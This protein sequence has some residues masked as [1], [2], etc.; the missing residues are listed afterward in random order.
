MSRKHARSIDNNYYTF[1]SLAPP[2]DGSASKLRAWGRGCR[3]LPRG[4]G[5]TTRQLRRPLHPGVVLGRVSRDAVSEG[6]SAR[7]PCHQS[8]AGG[9]P[10]A[11]GGLEGEG[12][13]GAVAPQHR[14][15]RLRPR[16]V[17]MVPPQVDG[18]APRATSGARLFLSEP[19]LVFRA[20]RRS[21]AGDWYPSGLRFLRFLTHGTSR[22]ERGCFPYPPNRAHGD[23]MGIYGRSRG[24]GKAAGCLFETPTRPDSAARGSLRP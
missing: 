22:A 12:R 17:H 11:A 13:E 20:S 21:L 6:I 24:R 16:R 14:P 8:M 7:S 4:R 1:A 18:A 10:G 9:P 15:H 19:P 5:P 3:F 23:L 2:P